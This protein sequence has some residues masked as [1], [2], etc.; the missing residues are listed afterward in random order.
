[1]IIIFGKNLFERKC[2]HFQ[3]KTAWTSSSFMG[4][5]WIM[6]KKSQFTKIFSQ[7][8]LDMK[9]NGR[10]EIF[11][12]RKSNQ[13]KQSC[14]LPEPKQ[15]PLGFKKLASLFVVLVSGIFISI[16][17]VLFEFITKI[18]SEKQKSTTTIED[19]EQNPVDHHIEEFLEALSDDETEKV[20]QRI[21]QKHIKT[22]HSQ[23][24]T[25]HGTLEHFRSRIPILVNKK[26]I[27][28]HP[29]LGN[30]R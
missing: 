19:H 2:V 4:V 12:G 30:P 17:V 7:A 23:D 3:F 5:S 14:T 13:N 15:K 28:G 8:I 21:V 20:F 29:C 24:M 22:S 27:H 26:E 1:M 18:A 25:S 9:D 10:L 16:F 11:H 6:N